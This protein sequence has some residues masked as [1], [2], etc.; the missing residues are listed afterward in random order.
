MPKSLG[1][2]RLW[3]L[4]S[5]DGLDYFGLLNLYKDQDFGSLNLWDDLDFGCLDVSGSGFEC[6]DFSTNQGLGCVDLWMN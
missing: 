5:L 1:A 6:L 3:M 2:S 4:E